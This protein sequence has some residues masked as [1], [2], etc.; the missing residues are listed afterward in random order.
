MDRFSSRLS[1]HLNPQDPFSHYTMSHDRISHSHVRFP[2]TLGPMN[3]V[4]VV[5][6]LYQLIAQQGH[7]N[8][9]AFV[10]SC[11]CCRLTH[12]LFNEVAGEVLLSSMLWLMRIFVVWWWEYGESVSTP[13][14]LSYYSPQS[15]H[16]NINNVVVLVHLISL[17]SDGLCDSFGSG[18]CCCG[19]CSVGSTKYTAHE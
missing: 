7:I 3:E 14:N 18:C 4:R 9:R 16:N 2:G 6:Q 8:L 5:G 19:A 12:S 11:G 1:M 17:F 15:S 13:V 10:D